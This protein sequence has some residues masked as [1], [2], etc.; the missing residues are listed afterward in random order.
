MVGITDGTS[1]TIFFGQGQIN[2]DDYSAANATPGYMNTILIG[3]TTATALSSNPVAGGVNFAQDNSRTR[4]DASRGFGGPF[5]QGCLMAMGDG[6]VRMFPYFMGIGTMVN[7]GMAGEQ[8]S[9]FAFL[10]P[11]GGEIAIRSSE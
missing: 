8:M 3:G 2:T 6:T 1:N 9:L 7:P 5:P 4:K 10:T 11:Q